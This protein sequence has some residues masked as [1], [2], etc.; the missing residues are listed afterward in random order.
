MDDLQKNIILMESSNLKEITKMERPMAMAGHIIRQEGSNMKV[1][2]EMESMMAKVLS[3]MRMAKRSTP[4]NGQMAVK[5]V[6]YFRRS[7]MLMWNQRN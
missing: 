1:C 2:G 7:M 5:P 3:M 4:E 6:L